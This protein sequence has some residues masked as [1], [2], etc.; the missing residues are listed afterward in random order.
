MK[1]FLQDYNM[2]FVMAAVGCFT[3]M[4]KSITAIIYY[5]LICQAEQM[6]TSDNKYMKALIGKFTASYKL[7]REVHNVKCIVDKSL[8]N[9]RFLGISAVGMKNIGIYGMAVEFMLLIASLL[10]GIY[11]HLSS[12]WYALTSL[13]A[14]AVIMLLATSEI[15][16]QIHR[17]YKLLRIQMTDYLENVLQPKLEKEYLHPEEEKKY[18]H[19]YFENNNEHKEQH[20]EAAASL[21]DIKLFEEFVEEYLAD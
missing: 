18:Q 16:F 7:K 13:S 9:M 11:Y 17:K 5:K 19:E 20:D 1:Q 10:L 14:I 6:G 4:M 3:V 8:H 12:E 15:L 21:E 2:V